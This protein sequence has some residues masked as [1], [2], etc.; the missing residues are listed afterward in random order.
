[1]IHKH[2]SN[3]FNFVH[4]K[5]L[6]SKTLFTNFQKLL[7]NF[8]LTAT[9]VRVDEDLAM[10]CLKELYSDLILRFCRVSDNQ[11]RKDLIKSFGMQ[12][13]ETLR[14]RVVETTKRDNTS[15]QISMSYILN[16]K[17]ENKI[18]SHLKLQSCICDSGT[19]VLKC[20]TK[21]QLMCLGKAYDI[22]M[23]IK[24]NKQA[25]CDN[26][27]ATVPNFISIQN[28]GTLTISEDHEQAQVVEN[29]E[30][31]PVVENLEHV[32]VV[33]NLEHVPVVENLEH[34]PVVENLEHV[35]VVEDRKQ[36]E[37]KKGSKRK[38][39]SY[40]SKRRITRKKNSEKNRKDEIVCSICSC[41]FNSVDERI[42]CDLC[43]NWYHK[44]CQN[45]TD[46]QLIDKTED[47]WYCMKCCE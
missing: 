38:R 45:I 26:L 25:M 24:D 11:F 23:S 36:S 3:V 13:S 42:Q 37:T 44:E 8:D 43:D 28:V 2:G 31:A 30:Q 22:N 6:S 5:L 12:K 1:M 4:E 17:S 39:K 20:F 10:A 19:L 33:E 16:E 21:K 47:D 7:Q 41:Q 27:L 9:F 34:V 46:D 35:P 18:S 40:T 32:P 14:K 15:E 29:L